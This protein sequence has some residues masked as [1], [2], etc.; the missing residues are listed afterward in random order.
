MRAIIP[1]AGQGT[2]LLPYSKYIH[3]SLLPVAGKPIL[4][5]IIEPLVS[6]G[7][8]EF[9]LVLGHFGDQIKSHMRI[10]KDLKVSYVYQYQQKG[11]GHAVLQGLEASDEPV[12]IVL[13][14]T[15]FELDYQ[16]FINEGASV[17]GVVEV[18]NPEAFGIVE[19]VGRKIVDMVEK[20]E[21]PRSNLAIAGIYRINNQGKL[22]KALER[23]VESN[24][25]TK[26]EYQLTDALRDMIERGATFHT[27][28]LENWLDCGTPE[29]LLD[30]NRHLLAK[31]KGQYVHSTATVKGS[32]I[33]SSAIMKDCTVIDTI[34]DNSIILAG[35]K[36]E[37][38]Y[39]HGEII[40]SGSTLS[41][42]NTGS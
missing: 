4:D 7:I 29:T 31:E 18:A 32:T 27:Q 33:R 11:L 22:K 16:T 9:C 36:L 23:L 6:A 15:I 25:T 10:Y 30:T 19:T 34:I 41:G 42:Y 17:V 28:E 2:R 35:A 21:Q 26:G 8:D 24:Q 40:K 1:I 12:L 38:C 39:I 14:D 5:R 3:K 13:S 37:K 20:P